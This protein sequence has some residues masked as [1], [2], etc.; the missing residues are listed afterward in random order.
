MSARHLVGQLPLNN[1]QAIGK[2]AVGLRLKKAFL[3]VLTSGF[4]W[5]F[6]R[7]LPADLLQVLVHAEEPVVLPAVGPNL[8]Q[9]ATVLHEVQ[10]I[11]R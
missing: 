2:R 5:F 11:R 7:R 8:D 4:V 3:L 1:W 9:L 10:A 6:G